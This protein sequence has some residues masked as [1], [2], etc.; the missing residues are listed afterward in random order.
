MIK[1]KLI[2]KTIYFSLLV[3]FIT[4]IVG[5]H[6]FFINVKEKDIILQDI[7]GL[8][9]IVQIVEATFYIW[10]IFALKNLQKMTPRRYID[11]FITTPTMLIST[12]MFMKYQEIKDKGELEESKLNYKNFFRDNK[13]N[14]LIIV[15]L[16]VFM[17]LFGYLGE[18]NYINKYLSVSVGFVFFFLNFYFIYEY[19]AKYSD[20]GKKLFYFN[21]II[22]SLYGVAAM[23]DIKTKNICYN[24]L[25]IVAKNFY[26]LYI[27]YKILELT[28][29]K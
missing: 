25:D 16:N 6:G 19:Y 9:T 7:L 17:L 4:T 28:Y 2:S 5:L 11:W 8:E 10:I 13:R 29:F 22:W 21:L 27:Y 24:L 3:Q 23:T 20:L 15:L 26:G 12:I 14:I 1:D 18:I